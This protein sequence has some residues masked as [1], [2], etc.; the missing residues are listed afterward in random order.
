MKCNFS[1][2]RKLILESKDFILKLKSSSF[3]VLSKLLS[4]KNNIMLSQVFFIYLT[5][6]N[7]IK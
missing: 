1:V 5:Q 7:K 6:K 2:V 4:N 3:K